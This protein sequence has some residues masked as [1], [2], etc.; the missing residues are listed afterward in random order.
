MKI[1]LNISR[2]L[3][4]K[5]SIILILCLSVFTIG[6]LSLSPLTAARSDILPNWNP[7]TAKTTLIEFVNRVSDPNSPDYVPSAERIAVFDNDGTLWSEKPFYFQIFF[8]IDRIKSMATNH[9][10]WHTTQPYQAILADDTPAIAALTPKEIAELLIVT[11]SGMTV[12]EFHDIATQWLK[13]AKHPQSARLFTAMVFQPM[14][15][16]LDYLRTH[17]FKTFIVSGGGVDF[18]RA[19]AE[20]LYNVPPEQVIGSSVKTQFEVRNSQ[21]VLMKLPELGS[22]ND[23]EGKPININL[24]IGRRPILAFGNSDGDLPMLQYTASGKRPSLML[25]LHH[26]DA[27]R[28]WAYDRKSSIGRLDKAWDEALRQGWT[29]VSLKK[30]FKR[31]YPN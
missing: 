27:K 21:Y 10:E 8:M 3:P 29:V 19:F 28:E 13:T 25:L 17:Q 30:D 24:H 14:L 6:F 26:D 23:K 16:L 9:P 11:Q 20:R 12:E 15:E 18:M 1:C 22:F 7:G 31:V 4:L 2:R 5:G